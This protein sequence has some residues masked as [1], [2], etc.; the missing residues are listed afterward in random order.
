MTRN[1]LALL[2]LVAL[3]CDDQA[4]SDLAAS[5]LTHGAA[6]AHIEC[7]VP[8]GPNQFTSRLYRATLLQD[9]ACLA[10][11]GGAVVNSS[12]LIPVGGTWLSPRTAPTCPV[13]AFGAISASAEG[14]DVTVNGVD[15]DITTYCTGF[16]LEAFGVSP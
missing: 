13:E 10:T 11:V 16:N 4:A 7:A 14:G 6:A 5:V 12:V 3:G 1:L 15:Y 9:G 2:A 8:G